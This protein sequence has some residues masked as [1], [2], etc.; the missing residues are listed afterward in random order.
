[1]MHWNNFLWPLIVIQTEANKTLTLVISSLNSSYFINYGVMMLAIIVA[2]L[3]II[4]IFLT[5][6][7]Q[8]VEGMVGSSK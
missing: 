8:F 4:I 2:T 7:R 6:Q 1:M 5:M 3:P